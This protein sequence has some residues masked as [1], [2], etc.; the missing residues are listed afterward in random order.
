MMRYWVTSFPSSVSESSLTNLTNSI[1]IANPLKAPV[2]GA[3]FMYSLFVCSVFLFVYSVIVCTF[4][5]PQTVK[6]Q[7]FVPQNSKRRNKVT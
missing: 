2:Y 6:V 1:S 3:F 5:V 4:V 7:I